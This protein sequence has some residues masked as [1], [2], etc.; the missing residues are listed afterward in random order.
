M[1]EEREPSDSLEEPVEDARNLERSLLRQLL[2]RLPVEGLNG[3]RASAVLQGLSV[4]DLWR[5]FVELETASGLERLAALDGESRSQVLAKLLKM[6]ELAEWLPVK[7]EDPFKVNRAKSQVSKDA[8]LQAYLDNPAVTE[9]C[10]QL[11]ITPTSVYY[12]AK[13]DPMF[14]AKWNAIRVDYNQMEYSYDFE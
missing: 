4:L 12:W 11:S 9:C 2:R 14:L 7:R 3:L 8:F 5:H 1:N 10:R 13:T 6:D